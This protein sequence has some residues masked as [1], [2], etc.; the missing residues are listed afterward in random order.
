ML[1]TDTEF[2]KLSRQPGS[3]LG[4]GSISAA[5]LQVSVDHCRINEAEQTT[6]SG[7]RD[8][9]ITHTKV[10]ATGGSSRACMIFM[11]W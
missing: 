11:I 8:G 10:F 7:V 1:R 2:K 4:G 3:R 5:L 6:D 9:C